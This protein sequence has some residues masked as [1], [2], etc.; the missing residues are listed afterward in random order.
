MVHE[1]FENVISSQFGH[2][3]LA[4]AFGS[5]SDPLCEDPFDGRDKSRLSIDVVVVL[6]C[7]VCRLDPMIPRLLLV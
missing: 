6:I 3:G 4:G 7:C 2:L 5:S 1:Y